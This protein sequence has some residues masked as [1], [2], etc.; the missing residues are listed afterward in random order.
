[1]KNTKRIQLAATA[2]LS[3]TII[4]LPASS[5]FAQ[6]SDEVASINFSQDNGLNR[7][8]CSLDH[9]KTRLSR[10]FL[11]ASSKPSSSTHNLPSRSEIT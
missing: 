6:S 4:I 1:M 10:L 2:V 9:F 8:V 5:V 7:T 11:P 3:L